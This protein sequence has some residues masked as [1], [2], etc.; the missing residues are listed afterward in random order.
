M[1]G[2]SK[3]LVLTI[4]L[5]GSISVAQLFA[6]IVAHSESLLID[7]A[8]MCVDTMTY[9]VNLCA[10][11]CH[12]DLADLTAAGLSLLIL[13]G[14]SVWG[15]VEACEELRNPNPTE[16]LN[17]D[18]VLGF[19]IWGIAFDCLSFYGFY[20]WGRQ[21]LL[22]QR[23][24]RSLEEFV[25][26][27][28]DGEPVSKSQSS[29]VNMRSAFLHVGADFLR[30]IVIV[31]EGLAVKFEHGKGKESDSVAALI[32]SVTILLGACGAI[33][34]WMLQLRT[35]QRRCEDIAS[36]ADVQHMVEQ[37]YTGMN[38]PAPTS[39]GSGG[40]EERPPRNTSCMQP[41]HV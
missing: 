13:F 39:I 41:S 25:S 38:K 20:R 22:S 11:R 17:Y 28:A 12:R 10:A 6:A 37:L 29:S 3:V 27:G 32:V 40:D 36:K 8:S 31:G 16:N 21:G 4:L 7:S 26:S 15:I 30:S 1:R 14:A 2:D 9:V 35:W 18:I 5:F 19:G 23:R 34:P 33:V 24:D